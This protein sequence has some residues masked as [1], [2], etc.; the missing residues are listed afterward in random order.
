M[1]PP[2]PARARLPEESGLHVAIKPPDMEATHES[3]KRAREKERGGERGVLDGKK[4]SSF[5]GNVLRSVKLQP[6]VLHIVPEALQKNSS[7]N[8]TRGA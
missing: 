8:V 6:V 4:E 2:A 3:Q 5:R 7:S 1:P